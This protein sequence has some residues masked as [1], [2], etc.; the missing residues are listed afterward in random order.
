LKA[1]P[2]GALSNGYRSLTTKN[3]NPHSGLDYLL[4]WILF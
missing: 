3:I 2:T 1:H 4:V